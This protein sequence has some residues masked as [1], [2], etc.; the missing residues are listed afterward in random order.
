MTKDFVS[1]IS[2]ALGGLVVMAF[3]GWSEGLTTLLIF[4][5]VDYITG[6]AVAGI[7]KSSPKTETGALE[8]KAGW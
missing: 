2:G 8:S 1:F 6:L 5:I 7:F 4:M 3:G